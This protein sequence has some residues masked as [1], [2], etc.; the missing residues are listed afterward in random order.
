MRILGLSGSLRR[1]SFNTALL[2]SAA[3][4]MPQGAELIVCSIHG[5][6]LYD[7]DA[8][9]EHGIPSVVTR[10]KEALA[11]ADGLIIATPEYNNSIPGTLKN[12]IDWMSRPTA[13]I[14]RVFGGKPVAIVGASAGGFGTILSQNAWLSVVRYLG[15]EP[16]CGGRLLVSRAQDVFDQELNIVDQAVKEQLKQFLIG[17][18]QFVAPVTRKSP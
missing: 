2:G 17:F 1:G 13:D 16:W 6:P 18:G 4:L 11:E 14:K 8:E 3:K 10:L 9:A 15:M 7:A 12:A 5:I